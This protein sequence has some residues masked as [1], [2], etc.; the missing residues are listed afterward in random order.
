VGQGTSKQPA[1][2]QEAST[3]PWKELWSQ[4][5]TLCQGARKPAMSQGPSNE[6]MV[7]WILGARSQQEARE[8]KSQRSS[9]SRGREPTRSQGASNESGSQQS[10]REP[11]VSQRGRNQQCQGASNKSRAREPAMSQGAG[12]NVSGS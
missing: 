7:P 11:A 2:G 4:V 5:A 8:P 1:K 9:E 12:G 3:G 10:A 6:T